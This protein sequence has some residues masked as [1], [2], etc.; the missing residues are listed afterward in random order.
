MT[1][2]QVEIDGNP[3]I[4]A[5]E[6]NSIKSVQIISCN[7]DDQ[8]KSSFEDTGENAAQILA[9]FSTGGISSNEDNFNEN[10]ITLIQYATSIDN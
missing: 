4:P 2:I 3:I 6:T 1:P 7:Q 8:S 9:Q 5:A 10:R